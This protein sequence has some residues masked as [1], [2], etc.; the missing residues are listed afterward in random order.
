MFVHCPNWTEGLEFRRV[1]LR[2]TRPPLELH[3]QDKKLIPTRNTG[4]RVATP[5]QYKDHLKSPEVSRS[6]EK[7]FVISR[8]IWPIQLS[9]PSE[10]LTLTLLMNVATI[11][12]LLCVSTQMN[13]PAFKYRLR[14][15]P[16]LPVNYCA[17]GVE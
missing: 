16:V 12:C 14:S 5:A 4:R 6:S 2:G 15:L 8:V 10:V 13:G 1:P 7:A 17:L 11:C 3:L 9:Q